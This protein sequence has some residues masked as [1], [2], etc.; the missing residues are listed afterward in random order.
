MAHQNEF[1]KQPIRKVEHLL[2]IAL[3]V[4]IWERLI[5]RDGLLRKVGTGR[6]SGEGVLMKSCDLDPI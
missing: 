6:D 4:G 2:I 1:L 5:T 3:H